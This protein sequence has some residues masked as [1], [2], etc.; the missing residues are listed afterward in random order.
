MKRK[1]H[2]IVGARP[3]YIKAYPVF[4][5]LNN[6]NLYEVILIN[7]GQHYNYNMSKLF[8]VEL[9]MKSPDVNFNVG[10]GTHGQQTAKIIIK[11]E[12]YILKHPPDLVIVFG[13]VNSTIACSLAASKLNIPIAHVE[14][15]LRSYDWTMPEEIN[16]VLT[17][18]LST[19]LFTTSP[20]AETNLNKEGIY[21]NIFY[22]GNTMIDTLVFLKNNFNSS[23]I[24]N[25]LK[26]NREYCL[27][28]FHRPSN[29]DNKNNLKKLIN[30]LQK[31][32][33]KLDCVF[34]VHPRTKVKLEE[35][36][37]INKLI[38]NKHFHL[39]DPIG[40]IDFMHL[41]QNASIVITDSGGIQEETTFFGVPCLTVRENTE[42]P[43]TVSKGSNK[44]I[45]TEY[46]NI[47]LEVNLVLSEIEKSFSIPKLWDGSATNRIEKTL[48]NY[49]N[50]II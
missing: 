33:N 41:Q 7:T 39:I 34:P 42:R 26:I 30:S 44:L 10:S 45:G 24:L 4:K 16:R 43:I 6:S 36:D 32:T 25:E 29:V 8:F 22:V 50:K 20:E 12:S 18:R 38:K 40:Y 1:V 46:D 19:L 2:I 9:G 3:N 13:D 31:I 27:L 11:Y 21:K 14:S 35:F 17:D 48:D 23:K 37:L 49:F 5:I 28:T 15:G 47:P